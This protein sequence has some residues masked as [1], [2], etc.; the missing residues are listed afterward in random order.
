MKKYFILAIV[1]VSFYSNAYTQ[2]I[3]SYFKFAAENNPGL[4][5]SYKAFEAELQREARVGNL[6]DPNLSFGYFIS[7]VETRVGPQRAKISLSQMFPWFGTL[8]VQ[9]GAARLEAE[10]KYQEFVDARNQL[11]FHV[12]RAYYPLYEL[13]NLIA[14]EEQ[15]LAIL[16]SYKDLAQVNYENN[17]GS[18]VD[19]LRVD[20]ILNEAETRLRIRRKK[21][22]PLETGFNRLLNRPDSANIAIGDSLPVS[23]LV[24]SYSRDSILNAN[25][26]LKELDLKVQAAE[27]HQEEVVKSGLPKIGVGLDYV[28]VDKRNDAVIHDNGKDAFMPMVSISLPIFRGKYKAA[29]KELELMQ[30]SY[31]LKQVE[32]SNELITSFE[33]SQFEAHKQLEFIDLY[34]SQ[35]EESRQSLDLLYTAYSNSGKDFEEVLRMQQQ[36]LEFEKMKITAITE[37]YLA[38]AQLNYITAKNL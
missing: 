10:A 22:K 16:S 1:I 27:A 6:P 33:M 37:Y 21:Q 3:E 4:K 14:L 28:F 18:L 24:D 36:I 2:S 34:T 31:A 15:N 32:T 25:P 26:T 35:I 7:P 17:K 9:K 19:V 5:A 23:D 30:E 20:M 12:A 8:K 29:A 38:L 13:K 11:Y